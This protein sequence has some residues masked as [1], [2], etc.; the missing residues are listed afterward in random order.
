MELL[1]LQPPHY[2]VRASGIYIIDDEGTRVIAG[3]F[4]SEVTAIDWIELRQQ[5]LNAHRWVC[6]PA[7]S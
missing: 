2:G 5:A 6:Q 4:Q 1:E 7:M 3:P